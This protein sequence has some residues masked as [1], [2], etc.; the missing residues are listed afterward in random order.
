MKALPCV[1]GKKIRG[2]ANYARH[3]NAC[4]AV[5]RAQLEQQRAEVE[6]RRI[7]E[8]GQRYRDEV[9]DMR[10][11]HEGREQDLRREVDR[12]RE[13]AVRDRAAAKRVV[14]AQ[15]LV[16]LAELLTTMARELNG[17][18]SG[19]IDVTVKAA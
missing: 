4:P 12:C 11:R 9:T 7:D 16:D 10:R 15:T 14:Q 6:R 8:L 19:H 3:V 1:C 2:R 17:S 18:S 13:Q 5:R